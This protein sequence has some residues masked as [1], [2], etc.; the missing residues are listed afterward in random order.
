MNDVNTAI[1]SRLRQMLLNI[2]ADEVTRDQSKLPIKWLQIYI[3]NI[4]Q[5]LQIALSGNE[6]CENPK[7][8]FEETK[9]LVKQVNE[10]ADENK[11]NM[12]SD[13]LK[14]MENKDFQTEEQKLSE[15]ENIMQNLGN[16]YEFFDFLLLD[17][18]DENLREIY[19]HRRSLDKYL[20]KRVP[21]KIKEEL[22]TVKKSSEEDFNE[23]LKAT[24]DSINEI[25]FK[26]GY[27]IETVIRLLKVNAEYEEIKTSTEL[28]LKYSEKYKDLI[29][30]KKLKEEK[31]EKPKSSSAKSELSIKK[32]T[33]ENTDKIST[34]NKE[35]SKK[36]N[37]S[38]KEKIETKSVEE[39][40]GEGT[41]TKQKA[42]KSNRNVI[43]SDKSDSIEFEEYLSNISQIHMAKENVLPV[44]LHIYS[45]EDGGFFDF[46][47]KEKI[48]EFYRL[49]DRYEKQDNRNAKIF[50]FTNKDSRALNRMMR[51]VQ[52]FEKEYGK[53]RLEGGISK[54]GTYVLDMEGR[55]IPLVKMDEENYKIGKKELSKIIN[56]KFLDEYLDKDE[57]DFWSFKFP[58][59]YGKGVTLRTYDLLRKGIL[60]RKNEVEVLGFADGEKGIDVILKSQVK[61]KDKI[62]RFC[63]TKFYVKENYGISF[64]PRDMDEVLQK[65]EERLAEEVR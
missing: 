41:T 24:M 43:K 30:E 12:Q 49:L 55:Q 37:E 63:K 7:Y 56:D 54:Y 29:N 11:R 57:K 40:K 9:R 18:S 14:M 6:K 32:A 22:E 64:A 44:F 46:F 34:D 35:N 2:F 5:A 31:K 62:S 52:I 10:L 48:Q 45:R 58:K 21:R 20:E 23:L 65:F 61:A 26:T 15:I 38:S 8:G 39:Q 47:P 25:S 33:S 13:T 59:D 17:V 3:Y 19:K 50:I 4:N 53:R 28:L 36:G 27:E 16:Q 60:R 1:L 51:E 42:K